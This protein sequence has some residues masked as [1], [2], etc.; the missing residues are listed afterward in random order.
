MIYFAGRKCWVINKCC[1]LLRFWICFC[2]QYAFVCVCGCL[3]TWLELWKFRFVFVS[4]M[5][6]YVFVGALIP[7]WN[8]RVFDESVVAGRRSIYPPVRFLLAA[9]RGQF[10]NNFIIFSTIQYFEFVKYALSW[11]QHVDNDQITSLFS[12]LFS[13]LRLLNFLH[14]GCNTWTMIK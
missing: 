6:L 12:V 2:M 4:K 13:I 1:R 10:S 9:T 8:G 3:D 14:L 7:G 11:L 5:Y